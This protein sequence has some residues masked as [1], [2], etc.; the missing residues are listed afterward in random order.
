MISIGTPKA[1][2]IGCFHP[3]LSQLQS[4]DKDIH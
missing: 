3:P 4:K 2:P 1:P